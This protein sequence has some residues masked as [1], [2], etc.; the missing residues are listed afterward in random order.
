MGGEC[1]SYRSCRF[2]STH[3]ANRGY[4]HFIATA[5][6]GLGKAP[7]PLHACMQS[8]GRGVGVMSRASLLLRTYVVIDLTVM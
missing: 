7:P 2:Q 1:P 4:P 5:V 6:K 3:L 8:M